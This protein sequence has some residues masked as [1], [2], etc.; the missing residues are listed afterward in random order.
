MVTR[1]STQSQVGGALANL[2]RVQSRQVE[3][4]MQ[5][6]S[7]KRAV[8]HKGYGRE[9]E[10]LTALR[11]VH[12]KAE[13][14]VASGSAA[15]DRL[16]T[17]D[18]ML[19][20][21]GEAAGRARKAVADALAAGRADGLMAELQSR[22]QQAVSSLNG[23]HQGRYL[24]AGTAVDQRPVGVTTLAELAAAPSVGSVF[25]NDDRR[26]SARLDESTTLQTGF[27]ADAV[28]T[29]LFEVFRA[30]KQFADGPG[31]PLQGNLTPAQ[32]SFLETQLAT[33]ATVQD[34]LI[35][36][37]AENGG[38]QNQAEA[39]VRSQQDHADQLEVMLADKTQV[40]MAEA[41]TRLQ[42]SQT[43]VQASAQVLATLRS[44]SLLAALGGTRI[45]RPATLHR[46]R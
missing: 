23:R 19:E 27:L 28:G 22:F 10:Q 18:L 39:A 8:D 35:G 9:A 4:Q 33:L 5:V 2:M 31:G 40:D 46:G 26:V 43:A 13:A 38:L 45:G 3:A 24:F 25:A 17:Q 34:G 11:N 41:I 20:Q 6:G 30:I 16:T 44:S 7:E 36:V 1:V 42:L 15:A 32:Q 14:F 29:E 12:A 21:A 37:V